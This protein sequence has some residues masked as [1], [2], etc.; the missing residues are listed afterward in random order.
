MLKSQWVIVTSDNG[1]ISNIQW[2]HW[3]KL[4]LIYAAYPSAVSCVSWCMDILVIS[5]GYVGYTAAGWLQRAGSGNKAGIVI[6][7]C[8][9]ISVGGSGGGCAMSGSGLRPPASQSRGSGV[10]RGS[11]AP[12]H[13]PVNRPTSSAAQ[14]FGLFSRSC[15][16]RN[17]ISAMMRTECSYLWIAQ[18]KISIWNFCSGHGQ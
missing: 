10:W 15:A 12:G 5:Y 17:G 13:S 18:V 2:D 8:G 7:Y 9:H 11:G 16:K 3:L 6:E 4:F 1:S 14:A